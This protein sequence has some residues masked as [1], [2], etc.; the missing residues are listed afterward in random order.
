MPALSTREKPVLARPVGAEAPAAKQGV[1]NKMT[2]G[3]ILLSVFT[4]A[5]SAINYASNLVF[6]RLLTPASY[7]DLTSLLS[8]SVVVA[9]VTNRFFTA[10]KLFASAV[11]NVV[12]FSESTP[13]ESVMR[14]ACDAAV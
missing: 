13:F 3:V 8:L 11:S 12:L 2:R 4:I 6:A 14:P 7:G 9:E 10:V 5:G 1:R